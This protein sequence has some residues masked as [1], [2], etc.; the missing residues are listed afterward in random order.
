MMTPL[1]SCIVYFFTL[2]CDT[3]T[4]F[5]EHEGRMVVFHPPSR[6]FQ[7]RH[8]SWLFREHSTNFPLIIIRSSLSDRRPDIF[9]LYLSY[10][11]YFPL[12]QSRFIPSV[13]THETTYAWFMSL[14]LACSRTSTCVGVSPVFISLSWPLLVR[15]RAS[16]AWEPVFIN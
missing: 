2:F 6:W 15:V 1:S 3:S 9:V 12:R 7:R 10:F 4:L 16:Y 13:D 14:L 11:T 8:L 5:E